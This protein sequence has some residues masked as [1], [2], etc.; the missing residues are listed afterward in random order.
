MSGSCPR[1]VPPAARNG[2]RKLAAIALTGLAS[3][4]CGGADAGSTAVVEVGDAWARATPAGADVGAVYLTLRS[5]REDARVGVEV[6]SAIAA[7]A[8]VHETVDAGNGMMSMRELDRLPLAAGDE[9]LIEPDGT[10]IMLEGL[11]APLE[12][13]AV[14]E[15]TLDFSDAPDVTAAV[16]VR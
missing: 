15:L 6:D 13:G 2:C 7:G 1:F 11:A 8:T 5:D 12:A 14:F 3:S 4:A 10:H 9:V 16:T